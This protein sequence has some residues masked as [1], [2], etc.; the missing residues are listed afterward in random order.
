MPDEPHARIGLLKSLQ[1][2][3]AERYTVEREIARGGMGTVY[4]ARDRKHANRAVA[5]K[6]LQP[7][8]AS[9]L[10][11]D[12]FLAEINT[13]AALNH[14]HIVPVFDSG[15]ANGLLY[16][17]MPFIEGETLRQRERR[18]PA[19]HAPGD[20]AYRLRH[21][22]GT[23]LRAP[24]RGRAPRH[25]AREHHPLGRRA[26]RLRLRHRPRLPPPAASAR[27][28]S[29]VVLGTPGYMSPEQAA[30]FSAID[31]RADIYGLGCVLYEMID[32][33]DATVLA[34]RGERA[35]RAH[36]R[37]ARPRRARGST[38]FR[39]ASR[40]RSPAR[41]RFRPTTGSPMRRSSRRR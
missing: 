32:G 1:A 24:A 33:R 5:L 9:A 19:A 7:D 27:R 34:R 31:G 6:V 14:P 15:D 11:A 36:H 21:R 29:G 26:G 30:G 38:R 18:A 3:L 37:G 39:P 12:R 28:G 10:G 17:V 35:L 40:P 23:Q 41:S 16:Y 8:V 4:L 2:S 20:R 22:V 13:S 25:Q